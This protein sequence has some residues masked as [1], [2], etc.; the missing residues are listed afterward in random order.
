[1]FNVYR[2]TDPSDETKTELIGQTH[3]LVSARAMA[4]SLGG[5]QI[6]EG[7]DGEVENVDRRLW[8]ASAKAEVS[9]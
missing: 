7:E 8:S 1:M 3:T 4:A 5:D 9:S 2:F 6:Q